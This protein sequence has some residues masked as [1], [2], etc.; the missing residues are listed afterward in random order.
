MLVLL[1]VLAT[2]VPQADSKVRESLGTLEKA[3]VSKDEALGDLI[4]LPRLLRE[5]ERRGSIPDS[6]L[7]YRSARRLEDN[8]AAIASAPGALHGGWNRIEPLH[9]RIAPG[10][11]DAEALCRVTIGGKPSKFRFWLTRS[12]DSWRTFDLEKLDG[13]YRLSVIGLQYT[14]GVHDDEDRQSLRDGVQTFQRAAMHLSR[15][16][17]DGA[18]DA[19]A[20][21]RRSTPP[22][23]VMDWI[24]LVDGQALQALGDWGAALRMADRVLVRQ[25]DLAVAHRLKAA[26]HA[27]LGDP[28]RAIAAG[29]EYLK[30]VG[31]DAEMWTLIGKASEELDQADAAVAAYRKG[32]EADAQDCACRL[33]LGRL[34]LERRKT[35]EAAAAL[36]AA[37]ARAT[38]DDDV[39][40]RAGDLLDRAGA[41]AEALALSDAAAVKRSDEAPVL[42]R[43]GRALRKLGRAKE[44]EETL[45]RASKL[46][47]DD[48]DIPG[49]LTLVLAQAGKDAEA[50][51]RMKAASPP[52][53]AFVHAAAGRS[54]AAL[55]EL[56]TAFRAEQDL[57]TTLGWIEKE[58]VFDKL[59]GDAVVTA[60][61]ATRDYWAARLNRKLS[62]EQMLKIAQDRIQA[63]PEDPLAYVD[64]C[65]MYR[66]MN[67]LR[68]AERSLTQVPAKHADTLRVLEQLAWTVAA[69]GRLD[70]ALGIAERVSKATPKSPEPGMDLRVAIFFMSGK[71]DAALKALSTLLEKYPAWHA[72]A[73][74]GDDLDEF[75]RLPAVQELLRKARSKAKK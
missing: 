12:G 29:Q 2:A 75:R 39:Y 34:L 41:H 71:R 5:M 60:A 67:M 30:L 61:R 44:A 54:E 38:A 49:E 24:D 19:L 42:L 37:V 46:H 70:D 31:D 36:T 57:A 52:V 11:D 20:M 56:R 73:L 1:A 53:R 13:T 45:T 17:A 50:Q 25:K 7:R 16:Q 26:C 8:L 21:A 18:R 14:P 62:P 22:E 74:A 72:S 40:E 6:N 66:R 35:D 33:E 43:R 3:L 69:Q 32:A 65:R 51:E 48:R 10:G 27:A 23:Y 55:D 58:P 68:E 4:D 59:R 63:L 64:E 47:P 15:G 28:T 9:V